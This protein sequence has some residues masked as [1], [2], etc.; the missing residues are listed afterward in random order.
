MARERLLNGSGNNLWIRLCQVCTGVVV[1]QG[2]I[3][4]K[5]GTNMGQIRAPGVS[6]ALGDFSRMAAASVSVF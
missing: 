4:A 5:L 1:G 6:L 3:S 2:E